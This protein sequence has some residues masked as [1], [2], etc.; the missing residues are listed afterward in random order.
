LNLSP[1]YVA[2]IGCMR[3]WIMPFAIS[4]PL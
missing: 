3:E 2:I 1:K 4:M